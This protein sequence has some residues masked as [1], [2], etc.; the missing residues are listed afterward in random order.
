MTTT[1]D[2]EINGVRVEF[3]N[4]RKGSGQDINDASMVL[5]LTKGTRSFLFTGDIG[6]RPEAAFL[7]NDI[8]ADV[9]K[10]PHHG[11]STSS[12]ESFIKKVSPS[13]AIVSSGF[14]NPFGMP[15][16]DVMERY[17][18]AGVTAVYRTDMSGAVIVTTDGKGIAVL[19]RRHDE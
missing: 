10:V 14:V 3:L 18:K 1:P 4:P 12:S 6:F 11:S 17:E 15:D 5:R 9:I 16:G 8:S 7:N 13:I 19:N 2:I